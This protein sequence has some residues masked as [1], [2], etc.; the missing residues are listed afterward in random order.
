VLGASVLY[1]EE[2]EPLFTGEGDYDKHRFGR[3]SDFCAVG[4]K[5]VGISSSV[6]ESNMGAL[7]SKTGAGSGGGG[8]TRLGAVGGVRR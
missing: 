7:G 8:S 5:S 1:S 6:K 4:L 2:Y 3:V